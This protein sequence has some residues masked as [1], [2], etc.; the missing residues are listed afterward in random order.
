[1]SSSSSED[2]MSNQALLTQA[3]EQNEPDAS[4][5]TIHSL[6][7]MPPHILALYV[8]ARLPGQLSGSSG[9]LPR[10]PTL[11]FRDSPEK[12]GVGR[13]SEG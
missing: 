7:M 9:E 1:M 8:R 13:R 3:K 6:L 10:G 12:G 11:S 5:F 2:N 4:D